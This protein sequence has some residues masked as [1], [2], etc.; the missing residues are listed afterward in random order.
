MARLEGAQRAR[1]HRIAAR[2]NQRRLRAPEPDPL[3]DPAPEPPLLPPDVP[4]NS[5]LSPSSTSA[6]QQDSSVGESEARGAH[7]GDRTTWWARLE[8]PVS[9]LVSASTLVAVGFTGMTIRQANGEQN[10]TREGQI[11]DRYTAA[12]T[13]LG[14]NNAEVRLGGL[15]ALQRI[16]QDSPRDAPTIV[17]V[18]CAYIRGHSPHETAHDG[19][20][21][22]P[23]TSD[24]AA[25]LDILKTP[26][27][28]N[29]PV[30]LHG[31]NLAGADLTGAHLHGANLEYTDLEDADLTA[32]DLRGAHLRDVDLTVAT[33]ATANLSGADLAVARMR[34][35]DLHAAD[36]TAAQMSGADLTYA[37][38]KI[39]NLHNAHMGR[40]DER[41]GSFLSPSDLAGADLTGANMD[42]ADL[43]GANV[44]RV[45]GLL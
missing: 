23:P 12:V 36:L 25:A 35:A 39:A 4:S 5:A 19:K 34:A 8:R 1:L 37:N 6:P 20:G 40:A 15:Y 30:D 29:T 27:D 45:R 14:D 21:P 43:T 13:N 16:A 33:L 22:P 44:T 26:L 18:I 31:A 2:I 11:T 42:G 38:L 28:E 7:A 10:L 17:N 3:P 9:L 41:N 32:A 24:M